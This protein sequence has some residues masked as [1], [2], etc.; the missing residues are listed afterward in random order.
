[1]IVG[2]AADTRKM[3]FLLI[4]IFLSGNKN[5]IAAFCPLQLSE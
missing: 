2:L 5:S 1:V 4:I 3:P